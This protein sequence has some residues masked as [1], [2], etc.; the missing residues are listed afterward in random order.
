MMKRVWAL[1]LAMMLLALP[2][3]ASARTLQEKMQLQLRDGSG[4]KGT[5]LLETDGEA[6][7]DGDRLVLRSTREAV[8]V[9]DVDDEPR[10]FEAFEE[11]LARFGAFDDAL[12]AHAA[13]RALERAAPSLPRPAPDRFALAPGPDDPRYRD[14]AHLLNVPVPYRRRGDLHVHAFFPDPPAGA[15]GPERVYIVGDSFGEQLREA[16]VRSGLYAASNVVLRFNELPPAREFR[17]AAERADAILFVYSAPSLAGSRLAETAE[18]L[19]NDLRPAAKPGRPYSL[20]RS[21]YADGGAWREEDA[22]RAVALDPGAE[23]TLVLPLSGIRAA[24][25]AASVSLLGPD[26]AEALAVPLDPAAVRGALAAV[27]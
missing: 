18:A 24:P 27:L 21:P 8:F 26:G 1:L 25:A 19:A 9:V 3:C 12:A 4:I 7:A 20:G 6:V 2:V 17:E 11:K 16:L 22:G 13:A 5:I 10:S 23:G 14:L 15:P